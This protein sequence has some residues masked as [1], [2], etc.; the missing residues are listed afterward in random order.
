MASETEELEGVLREMAQPGYLKFV[1][2]TCE[3]LNIPRLLC[4]GD[5]WMCNML[6]KRAGDCPSNKEFELQALID[7]Q[8]GND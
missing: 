1:D 7:L 3:N 8:V 5:V 4:H 6:W 2:E